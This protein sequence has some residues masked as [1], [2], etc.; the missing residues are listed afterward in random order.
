MSTKTS[1]PAPTGHFL[2]LMK[3]KTIPPPCLNRPSI[4]CFLLSNRLEKLVPGETR[5]KMT[6]EG[7]FL[8]D[9][10]RKLS[11]KGLTVIT[12]DDKQRISVIP[13]E[14]ILDLLRP[15]FHPAVLALGNQNRTKSISKTAEFAG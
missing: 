8:I 10:N 11:D 6:P 4:R 9:L 13:D 5:R 14:Q 12:T 3:V 2:D 7:D 15:E 1:A